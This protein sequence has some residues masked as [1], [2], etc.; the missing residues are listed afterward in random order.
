VEA[1]AAPTR[2]SPARLAFWTL[3]VVT[4]A[5]AAYAQRN[6]RGNPDAVYKY[7]TF[8]N[9]MVFYALW[10]GVILLIALNR[11]DLLALNGLRPWGRS[12]RLAAYAIAAIVLC[13]LVVSLIPLPKAPGKEQGLTPSHWES[14]HAGAFAAN[15]VLFAVAAPFVEEL[16]FRGL[17]QSL[18]RF[19]G[20][21]PSMVLVGVAF[22]L[23]HG[24]L[25]G[26]LVLIPFGIIVAWVRDRTGSVVP[27]MLVHAVFNGGTLILAVVFS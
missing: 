12:L 27:G 24:L 3:F 10:L 23:D 20:R 16:M 26:L 9:G 19:L 6:A 8:A 22:G 14:A 11:L 21:T 15:L 5:A 7:S 2:P 25:E 13:E 17:G 18:L 1:D 4:Y